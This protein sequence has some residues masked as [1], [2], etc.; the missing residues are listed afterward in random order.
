MQRLK[1]AQAGQEAQSIVEERLQVLR[2]CPHCSGAHIVRHGTAH[3]LQRYRCRGC[4]KTFDALTRTP[5][6]RLRC[7]ERW[8][9]QS[10]VLID[11]LSITAQHRVSLASPLPEPAAARQGGPAGGHRR[12]RRDRHPQVL[13]GPARAAQGARS[14]CAGPR[15]ARLQ[16]RPERRA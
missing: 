8:L 9:D 10:Q 13:Q 3:G 5:L 12:G 2:F 7:R 15:R 4:G 6:A 1:A 16:A 14:P 11:G